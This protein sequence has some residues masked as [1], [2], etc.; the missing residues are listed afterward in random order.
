MKQTATTTANNR[1]V[2]YGING[3]YFVYDNQENCIPLGYGGKPGTKKAIQAICDK[4]NTPVNDKQEQTE[5]VEGFAGGKW[6]VINETEIAVNH[7]KI[8]PN[9][10]TICC[11]I[12]QSNFTGDKRTCDEK[13]IE[14]EA[15]A[16][17]IASAPTLYRDNKELVAMLTRVKDVISLHSGSKVFSDEFEKEIKELLSNIQK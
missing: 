10:Q 4:L 17:L 1:Y 9:Y 5:T 2:Y 14:A 11:M 13:E 8:Y 12:E 3:E 7:S 15:N 6:E 16:K